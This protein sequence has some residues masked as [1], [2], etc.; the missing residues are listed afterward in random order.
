MRQVFLAVV[1]C[2][3]FSIQGIAEDMLLEQGHLQ[4]IKLD[5]QEAA[6]VEV[7]GL[8]LESFYS[9]HS[10]YT[11]F[12]LKDDGVF[13]GKTDFQA[14]IW[15]FQDDLSL[16]ITIKVYT[17][18]ALEQVQ[19]EADE[20]V[21]AYVDPGIGFSFDSYMTYELY[22]QDWLIANIKNC[23]GEVLRS[24]GKSERE[25]EWEGK[26]VCYE[27]YSVTEIRIPFSLFG[28]PEG[29]IWTDWNFV[30]GLRYYDYEAKRV[31]LVQFVGFW[32]DRDASPEEN[33]GKLR[34]FPPRK[35]A[36]ISSEVYLLK[37][38]EAEEEASTRGGVNLTFRSSST[39]LVVGIDSDNSNVEQEVAESN[40]THA[41]VYT[42]DARPE[43][44]ERRIWFWP[45]Y[46]S[47]TIED[48]RG[49]LNFSGKL[50][51]KSMGGTFD[52]NL[53]STLDEGGDNTLTFM[54]QGTT[55]YNA[56]TSAYLWRREK[57]NQ[58]FILDYIRDGHVK[59]GPGINFVVG[60]LGALSYDGSERGFANMFYGR[61]SAYDL[62]LGITPHQKKSPE[63]N[64]SFGR[65]DDIGI[66]L[67]SVFLE[68]TSKIGWWRLDR[69]TTNISFER[70]K[71][72]DDDMDRINSKIDTRVET[73]DYFLSLNHEIWRLGHREVIRDYSYSL[74][75]GK[76]DSK[77]DNYAATLSR[78][79][80]KSN[81]YTFIRLNGALSSSHLILGADFQFTG[82]DELKNERRYTLRATMPFSDDLSL[83]TSIA[84]LRNEEFKDGKENVVV[85]ISFGKKF[86]IILGEVDPVKNNG[87][88]WID[89][90]IVAKI[91][92]SL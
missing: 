45:Y 21:F 70:R 4:A 39:S 43:L 8:L 36:E 68:K 32:K 42:G 9:E 10:P 78:G 57:D 87:K 31:V 47:L 65:H 76:K 7:D 15:I 80:Y 72:Y 67:Q 26:T 1:I 49:A 19:H 27:D 37:E 64:N 41:V 44:L 25:Y 56:F 48:Y 35:K 62:T 16:I 40:P 85:V 33:T 61:V 29:G 18:P 74:S 30:P 63:F 71:N 11:T 91:I 20:K 51:S 23:L 83:S 73:P 88:N 82:Y 34:V 13:K 86:F 66:K 69:N 2:L 6:E 55:K 53:T 12:L 24:S 59:L 60:A 77:V 81:D 52:Y 22:K 38:W 92:A 50:Y 14:T 89:K 90:R 5:V 75:T 17:K 54:S 79:R 84:S 46:D 58:V 28:Y 3:L